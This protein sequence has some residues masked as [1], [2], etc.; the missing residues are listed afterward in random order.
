MSELLLFD[1][2]NHRWFLFRDV[3]YTRL[4][5]L[6]AG[7]KIEREKRQRNI[8]TNVNGLCLPGTTAGQ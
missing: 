2:C 5:C 3:S 4:Y 8:V 1:W 6:R 7:D